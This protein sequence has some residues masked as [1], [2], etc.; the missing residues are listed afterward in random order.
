[1]NWYDA[2]L[3]SEGPQLDWFRYIYYIHFVHK[4]FFSFSFFNKP[5]SGSWTGYW[6]CTAHWTLVNSVFIF[7]TNYSTFKVAFSVTVTE[8]IYSSKMIK[9]HSALPKTQTAWLKQNNKTNDTCATKTSRPS[10]NP[11]LVSCCAADVHHQ[12]VQYA[13][14]KPFEYQ[15]LWRYMLPICLSICRDHQWTSILYWEFLS[16]VIN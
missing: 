15:K 5:S 9:E 6:T 7:V 11:V 14:C 16:V 8:G 2:R 4:L 10:Q 12:M 1:M 3:G 13:Y